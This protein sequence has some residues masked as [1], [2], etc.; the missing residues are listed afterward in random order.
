MEKLA[1]S[2]KL[3]ASTKEKLENKLLGMEH[4]T[5]LWLYLAIEGVRDIYRESLR[6]HKE[7]ILLLPATVEDAYEKI[8]ERGAIKNKDNIYKILRIVVGARRPLTVNEMAVALSVDTSQSAELEMDVEKAHL[9]TN[10]RQWCGLFVFINHSRIY[11]IHQTAKEFL[12]KES[13]VVKANNQSWKHCLSTMDIEQN[14]THI[15]VRYLV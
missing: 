5:Y 1:S 12:I 13:T 14:M 2:L 6:P 11:L 4:R 15:C 8:L 9:E 10:L 7:S 3:D